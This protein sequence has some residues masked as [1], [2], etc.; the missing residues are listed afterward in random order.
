MAGK[1][2]CKR[3]IKVA[4]TFKVNIPFSPEKNDSY[5]SN[6]MEIQRDR[7]GMKWLVSTDEYY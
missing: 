2:V 7:D 6:I 1:N 3:E 5:S 4:L